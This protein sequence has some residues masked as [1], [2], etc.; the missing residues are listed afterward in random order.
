MENIPDRIREQKPYL[1]DR[2]VTST[3]VMTTRRV[4]VSILKNQA[5]GWRW[6]ISESIVDTVGV[7]IYNYVDDVDEFLKV[8]LDQM[9]EDPDSLGEAIN[10][11][12]NLEETH[13]KM[14]E[15]VNSK[16]DHYLV[17]TT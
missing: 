17:S 4:F 10:L 3:A 2:S 11:R 8:D 1:T 13:I 9:V 12:I 6:I 16:L 5:H 7:Y 15:N 14:R